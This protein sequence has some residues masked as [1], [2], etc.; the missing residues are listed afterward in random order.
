[1]KNNRFERS[2]YGSAFRAGERNRGAESDWWNKCVRE[3][4]EHKT[5]KNL[6]ISERP[7]NTQLTT[8]QQYERT[9]RRMRRGFTCE[10]LLDNLGVP[11]EIVRAAD[12]SY[13]ASIYSIHG[14]A[15]NRRRARFFNRMAV[16]NNEELPF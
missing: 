12:Y 5:E 3:V 4:L 7:K 10:Y 14:W 13:Q 6:T 8:R 2:P 11:N 1:M 16:L 15:S 9:Y